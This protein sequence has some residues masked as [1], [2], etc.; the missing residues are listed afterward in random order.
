M[1]IVSTSNAPADN[2]H[3]RQQLKA[4]QIVVPLNGFEALILHNM[5]ISVSGDPTTSARCEAEGMR[6]KLNE[7]LLRFFPE[8]SA[9]ERYRQQESVAGMICKG[10]FEC[11]KL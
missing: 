4:S 3:I 5:L 8:R 11:E 10:G 2:A 1:Q 9:A 6:E 7:Y